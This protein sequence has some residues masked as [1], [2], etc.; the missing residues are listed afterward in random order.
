[1][2]E[3]TVEKSGGTKE[4]FLSNKRYRIDDPSI[5]H[6]DGTKFWRIDGSKI[7]YINGKRIKTVKES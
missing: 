4:W 3:Y 7:W 2:I 1:M 5:E 6:A